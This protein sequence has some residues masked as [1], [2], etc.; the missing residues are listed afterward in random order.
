M[1]NYLVAIE[2]LIP[3]W[4]KEN[5]AVSKVSV[6]WHLDHSLKVVIGVCKQL[7]RA[8]PKDY[9]PKFSFLGAAIMTIGKIPRGKGRAPKASRT[10][11]EITQETLSRQLEKAHEELL[12]FDNFHSNA[13]FEHPYF[14]HMNTKK[15]KKFLKIHTVHHLAIVNDILSKE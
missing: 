8:N 6:G 1:A 15:A 7:E 14:G 2:R 13:F 3:E 9:R 12:K 4:K 11:D 5:P 10:T